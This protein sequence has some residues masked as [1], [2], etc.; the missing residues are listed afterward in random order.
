MTQASALLSGAV[1]ARPAT[2]LSGRLRAPGDKSIS[3][4]SLI[5]GGLARGE[6]RI[7][8]LLESEDV[9]N[10]GKAMASLGAQVER[11]GEGQWIV[12]GRAGQLNAPDE[13]LDCG[14]SGTGVRLL[15]G[16]VAGAGVDAEFIGDE[17]LSVRPMAR[18]TRPLSQMGASFETRDGC[19]PATNRASALTG[20]TY[21]P[22]IASAQVKSAILLAGL[23]ANGV[24][25]VEEA[26]ATRDHTETMLTAFGGKIDVQR[27]NGGLIATL[28]G[29]QILSG[30]TVDVPG[31]P[32]S[33]AF[34]LVAAL[35]VPGSSIRI[36]NVMDNEARIGLYTTL[37]EMG[38]DLQFEPGPVMAGERTRH[39]EARFSTLHGVEVPPERAPSMIDEYPVLS[40]AAASAEGE[41]RMMGLEELRAKESDRL[42]GSADL[43]AANG[44]RF[45]LLDDGLIVK[46]LGVGGVPGGGVVETRH[47]HRLAMSGL[48]LGL[49]AQN[50]VTVDETVMIAT[51]YPD[52]FAHMLA[53]GAPMEGGV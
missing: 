1:R 46:G 50:P 16:V 47:D 41:T 35:T 44:V 39:I 14:N 26:R 7:S 52:F 25:R 32:S 18:V 28:K 8:G 3:H 6:T 2:E 51:S 38:A 48:V 53:L 43:L 36:E 19:L 10:T 15:M 13:P 4:R 22:P 12:Q 40:V 45:E 9:L 34:A 49:A 27:E 42:A 30:Q 23:G 11:T 5:L 33:A 31:D 29:P 20:I 37:L 21:A 17:S 24:T